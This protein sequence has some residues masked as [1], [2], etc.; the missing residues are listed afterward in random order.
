MRITIYTYKLK[1]FNCVLQ[2]IKYYAKLRL[3]TMTC[4]DHVETSDL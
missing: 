4:I 3:K 1:K 2:D